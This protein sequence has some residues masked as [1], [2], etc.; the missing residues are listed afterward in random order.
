MM[1]RVFCLTA[2]LPHL[3]NEFVS[4]SRALAKA[5]ERVC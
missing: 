2:L 5:C 3:S 1:T 4:C